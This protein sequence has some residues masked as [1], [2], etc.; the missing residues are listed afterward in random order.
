MQICCSYGVIKRI[1][2]SG[3]RPPLQPMIVIHVIVPCSKLTSSTS[4]DLDSRV[5]V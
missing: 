4:R 3:G 1:Q 2:G 5:I